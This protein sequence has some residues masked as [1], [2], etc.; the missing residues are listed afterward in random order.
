[1]GFLLVGI[2]EF[3]DKSQIA[4][5]GLMLRYGLSRPVFLGSLSAQLILNVAYV[6]LGHYFGRF[7]PVRIIKW[8]G[9]LTFIALGIF[10]FIH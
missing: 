10:A 4:T 2:T 9:G 3:A 7:I 6:L 5:A 1:M 8:I